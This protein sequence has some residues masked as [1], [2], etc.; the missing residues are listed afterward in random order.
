MKYE[1]F[2]CSSIFDIDASNDGSCP[3]CGSSNAARYNNDY[4]R[5]DDEDEESYK[6][7]YDD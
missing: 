1:C 7:E 2:D 5:Y 6:D 3:S 4:A